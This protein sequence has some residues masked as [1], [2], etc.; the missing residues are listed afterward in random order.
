VTSTVALFA[1]AKTPVAIINRLNQETV[2][3][4]NRK[5]VQE[6]FFGTGAETLGTSPEEFAAAIK[7]D[8]ARWTKV[9]R[10]AGIGV[11]K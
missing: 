6:R 9:I 4:L 1:P 11:K 10:D 5:D 7:A 2:R 3:Y 8:L